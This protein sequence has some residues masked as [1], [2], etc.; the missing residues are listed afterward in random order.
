MIDVAIILFYI[1]AVVYL[2]IKVLMES[3]T[4]EQRLK[5]AYRNSKEQKERAKAFFRKNHYRNEQ[6][7]RRANDKFNWLVFRDKAKPLFV[8]FLVYVAI[9][10]YV[11]FFM[12][13]K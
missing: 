10:T 7:R 6:K 5:E 1:I 4:E 9:R 3:G 13:P 8:T 2:I 12:L 11:A